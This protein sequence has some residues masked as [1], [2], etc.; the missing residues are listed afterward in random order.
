MVQ[1]MKRPNLK[2]LYKLTP[3][4][5]ETQYKAAVEAMSPQQRFAEMCGTVHFHNR[6]LYEAQK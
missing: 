6:M 5:L 1:K 2:D 3:E 4:E